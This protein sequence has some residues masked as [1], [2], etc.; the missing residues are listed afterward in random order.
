MPC[1]P[2]SIIHRDILV[3][4]FKFGCG[5]VIKLN[6]DEEFQALIITTKDREAL[7]T[8][9]SGQRK[10]KQEERRRL[11]GKILRYN[12][13]EPIKVWCKI[14]RAT[15]KEDAEN[16]SVRIESETFS[17]I[18][19]LPNIEEELDWQR[20][21]SVEWLVLPEPYRSPPVDDICLQIYTSS[22]DFKKN[23]SNFIKKTRFIKVDL[24]QEVFLTNNG[25]DRLDTALM[26]APQ[27]EKI[28]AK[29]KTR[30]RLDSPE[31]YRSACNLGK[32]VEVTIPIRGAGLTNAQ[33]AVASIIGISSWIPYGN[34]S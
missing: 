24:D 26:K 30:I 9:K 18:Q 25:S 1:D 11:R 13:I 32:E 16:Q 2:D 27:E 34:G 19:E 3:G 12:L 31:S 6:G 7:I 33:K 17:A 23:N 10:I 8:I 14:L 21:W 20:S 29:G 5:T 22:D 4:G 28:R 15:A